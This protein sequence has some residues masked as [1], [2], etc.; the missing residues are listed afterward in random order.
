MST[1]NRKSFPCFDKRTSS[2]GVYCN[3]A[4]LQEVFFSFVY[5]EIYIDQFFAEQFLCGHLLLCLTMR[6]LGERKKAGRI[7]AGDVI[8]AAGQC[9]YLLLGN[10]WISA[11][12]AVFSAA[13]AFERGRRLRGI[14]FLLFITFCFGGT[15]QAVLALFSV[16][17]CAGA[18]AAF[19]LLSFSWRRYERCRR[20]KEQEADVS[21][22]WKGRNIALRALVDT[23]NR[24]REPITQ[25]PVSI[26]DAESARKFLGDGWE[27]ENGFF[28]VPY[29]SIGREHGWMRAVIL[30]KMQIS[31]PSGK[32]EIEKPL[33]AVSNERVSLKDTYQV[34]LN[35]EHIKI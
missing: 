28:L 26:L 24:L 5:F 13:A 19:F 25:K 10:R 32:S 6:V 9:A 12:G 4:V 8:F 18:L 31:T 16:P 23:G 35:P 34:I 22:F 30:D 29:H 2:C 33:L 11:A 17:V 14:F 27:R 3:H 20:Q 15:L 21:L 7:L 1:E